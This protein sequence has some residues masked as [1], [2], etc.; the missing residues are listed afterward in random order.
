MSQGPSRRLRQ[1]LREDE[2]LVWHGKPDRRAFYGGW[3]F[4]I[5]I[6][7]VFAG[8]LVAF[9]TYVT[10][11]PDSLGN[12][13]TPTTGIGLGLL[14]LTALGAL[15]LRRGHR[16]AEYGLTDDRLVKLGGLY[17][18]DATTLSLEDIVDVD[19]RKSLVDELCGTGW[20]VVQTGG[21]AVSLDF[22]PEPFQLLE[23]IDEAR[24]EEQREASP[25][26]RS[27]T[28]ESSLAGSS[29]SR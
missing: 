6:L 18:Q 23:T 15:A 28:R 27:S 12:L 10:V 11:D 16:L 4:G 26:S 21:S 29:A 22:V 3:L 14:A 7:L 17:G 19:V 25:S 8:P 5:L 13:W 24:D 2:T 1:I 9:A 20:I